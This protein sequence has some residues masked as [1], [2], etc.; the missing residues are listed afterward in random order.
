MKSN[1]ASP[2]LIESRFI[3][4]RTG[5][6]WALICVCTLITLRT[7]AIY[8]HNRVKGPRTVPSTGIGKMDR[9][10]IQ[11]T[12]DPKIV[13]Q[14][15]RDKDGNVIVRWPIWVN[16]WTAFYEETLAL[17]QYKNEADFLKVYL[18]KCEARGKLPKDRRVLGEEYERKRV[19]K[20]AGKKIWAEH[21]EVLRSARAKEKKEQ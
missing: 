11:P 8:Y 3:R 5:L 16:S 15:C 6:S 18:E 13:G 4:W 14:L 1:M 12:G 7:D 17:G 21:L 9:S 10:K 20:D 19:Y 2:G